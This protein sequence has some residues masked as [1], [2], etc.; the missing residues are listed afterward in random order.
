MSDADAALQ[1]VHIRIV[2]LPLDLYAESSEH[3]DELIR[4]FTLIKERESDDDDSRA[5][6]R[7]LLEL[8]EALTS[9]YGSFTTGQE[10]Q[11][12]EALERGDASISLAYRVPATVKQACV[13]LDGLLDEADEFCREGHDLL[14]LATPPRAVAF[15]KW[16]LQE[17]VRQADGLAPRSWQEFQALSS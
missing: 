1:L 2:D 4:E 5:V 12:R 8:V 7:R 11:L 17:F 9:Q 15:R 3:S 14:T 6:P 13:D 10:T 16:F